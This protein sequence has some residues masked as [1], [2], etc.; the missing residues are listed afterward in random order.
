MKARRLDR[1]KLLPCAVITLIL[2]SLCPA[3]ADLT[4]ELIQAVGIVSVGTVW[5]YT[6][7]T[8]T[9]AG[10]DAPSVIDDR[11]RE[12][13]AA[14]QERQNTDHYWPLTGTQVSD[15]NAGYHRQV[16]FYDSGNSG[17]DPCLG[18]VEVD[19]VY[20]MK[21]LDSA[22]NTMQLT[23]AGMIGPNIVDSNG[24][25]DGE[26]KTADIADGTILAADLD[27][28]ANDFCDGSTLEIDGT[29][30]LR[31]KT[32]GIGS[33]QIADG[34]ITETD[35]AEGLHFTAD[36]NTVFNTSMTA[37]S[38]WQDLDLS[39]YVGSRTALVFLEVKSDGTGIAWLGKP[40]GYGGTVAQHYNLF[41]YQFGCAAVHFWGTGYGYVVLATD[42]AGAIQHAAGDNTTTFTIKLV[43]W[44]G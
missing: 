34:S 43:G 21:F 24:I 15:A 35:C 32:G 37:A 7:D 31:V 2:Y 1:K 28:D 10:S 6:Y 39:S 5:T 11:I 18:I 13:K 23:S 22:D 41:G 4:F 8:T 44:L 26:V 19:G 33:A 12:V 3:I 38:T 25:L 40:K 9:P 42:S 16:T 17:T 20:E 29:V 36:A 30:G 27:A 14:L